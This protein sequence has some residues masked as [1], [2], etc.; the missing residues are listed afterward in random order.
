MMRVAGTSGDARGIGSFV[1]RQLEFLSS[2]EEFANLDIGKV[3]M[4][5]RNTGIP[6][7]WF[8]PRESR[9]TV[10]LG[11]YEF[12]QQFLSILFNRYRIPTEAKLREIASTLDTLL[13]DIVT[14]RFTVAGELGHHSLGGKSFVS[15]EE[16]VRDVFLPGLYRW[17]N[18]EDPLDRSVFGDSVETLNHHVSCHPDLIFDMARHFV[19]FVVAHEIGH[20][21]FANERQSVG[22]FERICSALQQ[23]EVFAIADALRSDGA[24]RRTIE[25]E[26]HAD[27]L[28]VLACIYSQERF[29][30]AE[31]LMTAVRIYVFLIST[32]R[33]LF[34][35]LFEVTAKS[36]Y[37]DNSMVNY[38]RFS[39]LNMVYGRVT[40]A[41]ALWEQT[42]F[43]SGGKVEHILTV[44]E[45]FRRF[46]LHRVADLPRAWLDHNREH[47]LAELG[48]ARGYVEL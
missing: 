33:D 5:L 29:L 10:D 13:R 15:C 23:R 25:E 9:I 45:D 35:F 32:L 4:A 6:D 22:I 37:Q 8:D 36:K 11:L 17:P 41:L 44:N 14:Q 27:V 20:F 39:P 30:S 31:A 40:S 16:F 43:V 47:A 24:L 7:A 12:A 42:T 3:G 19:L 48:L 38:W 2:R 26:R 28:A 34:V 1:L 46:Q 21:D 18:R